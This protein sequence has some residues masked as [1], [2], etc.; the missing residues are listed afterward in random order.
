MGLAA[1]AEAIKI[2][3]LNEGI[4]R[5]L[6]KIGF[7]AYLGVANRELTSSETVPLGIDREER[8]NEHYMV[9]SVGIIEQVWTFPHLT[10]QEFVSVLFLDSTRWTQQCYSV[11][12]ISHSTDNF[13]L[14][15][16][17]VR[18]LCGLLSDESAAILSI[19]YRYLTP[20]P[21]VMSDLPTNYQLG[22]DP[23]K[24]D[25]GWFEFTDLY[26]ELTV[27]LFEVSSITIP[28]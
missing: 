18:F 12:Y 23:F 11:R 7:H 13:S 9:E 5:C 6:H 2:S 27:I 1:H 28:K 10:M 21:R 3:Q 26:L 25:T 14:F 16:M 22:F 17:V 4:Q 19:L 24:T 8:M 15:K 20:S